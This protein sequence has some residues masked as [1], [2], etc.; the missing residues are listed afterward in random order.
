MRLDLFSFFVL[1]YFYMLVVYMLA[2]LPAK[3]ELLY[4]APFA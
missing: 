2:Q 3:T 1:Q 4:S